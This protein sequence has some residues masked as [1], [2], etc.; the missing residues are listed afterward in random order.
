MPFSMYVL[1]AN[2]KKDLVQCNCTLRKVTVLFVNIM[3]KSM[4][5]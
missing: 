2:G 3:E 5:E 4:D 1:L